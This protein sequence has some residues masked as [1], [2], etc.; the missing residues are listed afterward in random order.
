VAVQDQQL[1]GVE[2]LLRW[3]HPGRGVVRP[4]E[5]IPVAEETGLIVPIGE[6]ALR[7][8]C[9]QVKAWP[10]LRVSVNLS[11]VQFKH[12][13][14][15]G[16]IKRA[17]ADADLEPQRLELEVTENVLLHDTA[18][19]LRTLSSLKETGVRIWMDDFGT[20]YSSL[21]YLNSFPFDGLKIDRSFVAD[22][23][24]T[25]KAKAIVRSVI[26]LGR[27]LGMIT[28]AEGVETFEQLAFLASEGCTQVQGFYFGPAMPAGEISALIA[29]D[30]EHS[31]LPA[32]PAAA[33]AA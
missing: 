2:S 3:R 26:S 17:L 6:W 14:L 23:N 11:P 13:E 15:V 5:F 27:S 1:T 30:R 4:G 8:A 31:Q 9:R 19:A 16:T 29:A 25:D 20:G 22:L 24:A 7:T 33:A 18:G 21:S 32:T 10:G 28:N 12:R